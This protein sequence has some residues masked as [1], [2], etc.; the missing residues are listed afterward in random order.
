MFCV[1]LF[2]VRKLSGIFGVGELILRWLT[3]GDTAGGVGESRKSLSVPPKGVAMLKRR[4]SG[5]SEVRVTDGGPAVDARRSGVSTRLR[6]CIG[7]LD[8]TPT[9]VDRRR[10]STGPPSAGKIPGPVSL[11]NAQH[12]IQPALYEHS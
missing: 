5:P 8:A 6:R 12:K 9:K 2:L 1:T 3:T 4:A 10:K 7:P 11:L